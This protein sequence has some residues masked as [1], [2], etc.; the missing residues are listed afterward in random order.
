MNRRRFG[1]FSATL[2]VTSSLGLG[3][4]ANALSVNELSNDQASQGLKL[5]LEKGAIAAV[6]QL[7]QPNGFLGNDKVRIPLPKYLESPA[8]LLRSFGQGARLEELIVAMNHAAETSVPLARDMLMS[9]VKSMNVQDAKKILTGG[10]T[11]VT[12]FFAEKT[13]Q[14]LSRKFLPVVT[15]VTAQVNL[16]DQYNLI[17]GKA[18]G[19]GLLRGDQVSIEQYVTARTLDGLYFMIGEEERKIRQDPVGTGSVLLQKVFGA[20]RP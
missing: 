17:A 19:M 16:A 6:Q 20:L 10:D 11:S 13:R 4:T 1:S 7:G 9:A 12:G 5:A 15:K 8:K 18:A 2:L 14:P 3:S